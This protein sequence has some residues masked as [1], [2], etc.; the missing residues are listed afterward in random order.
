[1]T[2]LSDT[3]LL[4]L[5]AVPAAALLGAAVRVHYRVARGAESGRLRLNDAE[6]A[7]G[8]AALAAAFGFAS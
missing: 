1:M 3:F 5:F 8:V 6:I 4:G 2:F 7:A